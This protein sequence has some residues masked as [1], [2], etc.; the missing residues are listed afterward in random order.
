MSDSWLSNSRLLDLVAKHANTGILVDSS[1]LLVLCV[2]VLDRNRVSQE[3]GT[4]E[5]TPEDFDILSDFLGRFPRRFATPNILTE[6]SNLSGRLREDM[7]FLFRLWMREELFAQLEEQYVPTKDAMLHFVF[8]RLGVTDA[9][10]S[11]IADQGILVLTSDLNLSIMLESRKLDCI[12]FR[13][14]L[15]SYVLSS[16]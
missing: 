16:E 3:K 15:G 9:T 4:R 8:E 1:L 12:L 7:R 2:G 5:Y 6:L 13:R 10:I 11:I 14:D